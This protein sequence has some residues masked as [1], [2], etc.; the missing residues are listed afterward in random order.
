VLALPPLTLAAPATSQEKFQ[1]AG[2]GLLYLAVLIV[3]Y[4]ILKG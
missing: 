2:A 3:L 4:F 1:R